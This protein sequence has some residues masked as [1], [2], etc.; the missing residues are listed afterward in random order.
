MLDP[1][2]VCPP[3]EHLTHATWQ[4]SFADAARPRVPRS[5][6]RAILERMAADGSVLIPLDEA[7]ARRE[8]EVVARCHPAGVAI[9]LL[10]AYRNPAHELALRELVREVVG[11]IPCSISSEVSQLAKE[12]QRAST[13]TIDV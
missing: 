1:G 10:H 5:L 7:Q 2:R 6:R 3:Y 4:G 12:Y 11:D 13:T 9:C 8:L